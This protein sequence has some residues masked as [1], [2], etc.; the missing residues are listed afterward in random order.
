MVCLPLY[1]SQIQSKHPQK[2]KIS[3][4]VK[5]TRAPKIRKVVR[6]KKANV[7]MKAQV[8]TG[9]TTTASPASQAVKDSSQ[10]AQQP[11][12]ADDGK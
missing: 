12:A 1:L 5:V 7:T 3:R 10:Q 11:T 2:I 6:V 4:R 9:A 8:E